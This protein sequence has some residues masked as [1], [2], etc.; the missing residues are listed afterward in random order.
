MAVAAA[1]L[2]H[3]PLQAV[4]RPA[5]APSPGTY[6]V[7]R[8]AGCGTEQVASPLQHQPA[9]P[10]VLQVSRVTTSQAAYEVSM[11]ST[12]SMLEKDHCHGQATAAL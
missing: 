6:R 9:Q 11:V 3:A 8:L 1:L 10:K 7:Q 12:V 5:Q 4:Q 2:A